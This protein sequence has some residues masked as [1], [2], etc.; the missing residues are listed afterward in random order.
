MTTKP[1]DD[2][3]P[4]VLTMTIFPPKKGVRKVVVTGAPD[5]E[6]P[7]L[8]AGVFAERHTLIDQAFSGVLKRDPQVVTVKEAKPAKSK[9]K[10]AASDDDEEQGG[11]DEA[12]EATDQLV[13]EDGPLPTSP[14]DTGE[15]QETAQ[16]SDIS[17]PVAD[18]PAIEGDTSTAHP[19]TAYFDQPQKIAIGTLENINE[20]GNDG[21]QD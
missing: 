14:V 12:V 3:K 15:E 1:T 2:P 20:V 16:L 8:L 17:E 21:E 11:E 4:I 7:L 10:G 13:S 9:S 18:L 6:M 5:G 19:S